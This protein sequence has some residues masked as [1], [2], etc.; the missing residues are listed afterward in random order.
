MRAA[1]T[2]IFARFLIA[3]VLLASSAIDDAFLRERQDAAMQN[4]QTTSDAVAV[5]QQETEASAAADEQLDFFD[6]TARE[7]GALIDSSAQAL[8][9]K[10]QLDEL[11]AEVEDSVEEMIKLIVIFLLQTIVLPLGTLWLAWLA[12]KGFWRWTGSY[13][14]P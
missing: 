5:L 1:S 6:R 3:V 11:E 13:D 2:F 9:V 8:D 14:K 10:A 12:L 4:L 7:I